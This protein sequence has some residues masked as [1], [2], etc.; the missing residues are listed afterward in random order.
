MKKKE[1]QEESYL[2]RLKQ[3]F[4]PE[5]PDDTKFNRLKKNV[6]FNAGLVLFVFLTILLFTVALFAL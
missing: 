1:N 6:F 4:I 3:R 5:S 2:A